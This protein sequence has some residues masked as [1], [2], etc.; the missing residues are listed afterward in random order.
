MMQNF[1]LII[2]PVLTLII[3]IEQQID[4]LKE[5]RDLLFIP[6]VMRVQFKIRPEVERF[7]EE[8]VKPEGGTLRHAELTGLAN[9]DQVHLSIRNMANAVLQMNSYFTGNRAVAPDVF[10]HFLFNKVLMVY[11]SSE[12]MNDALRMFTILNDRGI[13]L[14]N[15]D[16]FKADNLREL[17]TEADKARWGKFWEE[18]ES[19]YQQEGFDRFLS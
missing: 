4:K 9:S 7:V 15:S 6:E 12:D 16:I 1:N 8:F 11:V 3:N 14:S 18:L 2:S 10:F 13:K 19:E 17:G 5:A